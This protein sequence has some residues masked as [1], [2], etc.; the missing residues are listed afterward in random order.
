MFRVDRP[1]IVHTHLVDATIAGVI[2]ARSARVPKIIIHEH[3]THSHYSWKVRQ[4][5]R[6][7]RPFVS[8]TICYS[9]TVEQGL[10][11]TTRFLLTPPEHLAGSS[12]SIYN[13]VD[14]ERIELTRA[15]VDRRTV[16]LTVETPSDALVITSVA[17]LVPWKGQRIL[18]EA[19]ALATSRFPLA[20]L[21][22]VGEGLLHDELRAR[23]KELNLEG[24]VHLLGA[25]VDV[26]VLLLA[27][28]VAALALLYEPGESG[29]AIGVSGFEAMG[30]GLP[31]I[32]SDYPSAS[33]FIRPDETGVLV[34]P[35]D[36]GALAAAL[37]DLL[38]NREKRSHIG[39]AAEALIRKHM[40]WQRIV[41]VYERI[42][43]LMSA[44]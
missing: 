8:L 24:R 18:L 15:T 3:Q 25:R 9:P 28:D 33:D 7:L 6:V 30:C 34:P 29:E 20:H 17:R 35:R 37:S 12:Y 16:R 39:A 14:L 36:I 4:A 41:P 21:S 26:Y 44:V 43:E 23:A 42:Y 22:L 31:L 19:F 1:D 5:Y 13:G 27:S 32:A 2:A 10:F 40:T 38:A 11:S